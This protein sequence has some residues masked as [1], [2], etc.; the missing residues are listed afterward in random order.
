MKFI[1]FLKTAYSEKG[2]P[3]SSRIHTG[4]TVI[5][6]DIALI[7]GFYRVCHDIRLENYIID[8]AWIL[9]LVIGGALGIQITKS[10]FTKEK[11]PPEKPKPQ[12]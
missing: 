1:E 9:A 6:F 11:E 8:Y 5:S 4:I 2:E 3:S 7:A 12:G 10:I